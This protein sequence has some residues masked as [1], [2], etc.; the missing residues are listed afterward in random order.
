MIRILVAT[1]RNPLKDGN[2][3]EIS[4]GENFNQD[5]LAGP[6]ELRFAWATY[7][8]DAPASEDPDAKAARLKGL[9]DQEIVKNKD[10]ALEP[11]QQG[12]AS[13]P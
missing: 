9:K 10:K 1:N 13:I 2:D 11:N 6:V 3:T 7:Q 8:D 4:F 5:P 12:F